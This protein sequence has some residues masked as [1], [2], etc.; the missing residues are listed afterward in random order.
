MKRVSFSQTINI[1]AFRFAWNQV[2]LDEMVLL[3]N[4]IFHTQ[5]DDND[6]NYD[7]LIWGLIQAY[8]TLERKIIPETVMCVLI[9]LHRNNV[10]KDVRRL[11]LQYAFPIKSFEEVVDNVYRRYCR[12]IEYVRYNQNVTRFHPFFPNAMQMCKY[13]MDFKYKLPPNVAKYFSVNFITDDDIYFKV[14]LIPKNK[15]CYEFK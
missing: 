7:Q 11:I 10:C 1:Y 2:S 13:V 4:Y 12:L 8:D 9:V 14:K 3:T 5:Y 15:D 6:Y